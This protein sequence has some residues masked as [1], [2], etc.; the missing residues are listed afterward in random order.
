MKFEDKN[1]NGI[2]DQNEKGLKK[3]GKFIGKVRLVFRI[4]HLIW[5]QF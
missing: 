1:G 2:K 4:F 5:I 3:I